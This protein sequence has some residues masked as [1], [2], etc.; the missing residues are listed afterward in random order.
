MNSQLL[1]CTVVWSLMFGSLLRA[2]QEIGFVERFA[3]ASDRAA[4]LTELVTG[5][6]DYYFYHALHFQN[7]GK[8]AELKTL[9]EEWTAR[10]KESTL[11]EEIQRRQALITYDTDPKATLAYLTKTLHL[12][13]EHTQDVPNAKP[14]FP[15]KL[16]PALIAREVFLQQAMG[17][18][19]EFSEMRLPALEALVRD[20]AVLTPNQRRY[21]I[22]ALER[23]DLPGLTELVLQDLQTKESTGFGQFPIHENLL[24]PQLESLSKAMP[25]LMLSQKFVH[26]WLRKLQP[27]E[28]VN[29]AT[30][31]A[32]REQWLT[33]AYAF[34]K[35]LAPTFNSLKAHV[36]FHRL[37]HDWKLGKPNIDLLQAYLALPWSTPHLSTFKADEKM[38][39]SDYLKVGGDF[40][41]IT[42]FPNVGSDDEL[43]RSYLLHFLAGAKPLPNFDQGELKSIFAEANLTAGTGDAEKLASL[44]PPTEIELLRDRVD[45]DFAPTNPLEFSPEQE[46]ALDLLIKNV[47][48]LSVQIFELN[49][50]NYYRGGATSLDPGI[51]LDGLI[52]NLTQQADYAEPPMRRMPRHFAFP[53]LGKK[54]GVWVIDFMGNGKSSRALIRKG[55][56]KVI[57]RISAAGT[58]ITVLDEALKPIPQATALVGGQE[59]KIKAKDTPPVEGDVRRPATPNAEPQGAAHGLVT[60]PSTE[61][62]ILLPFSSKPGPQPVIVTD[63]AGFAQVE[64]VNLVDEAYELKAGFHVPMESL[65][66]GHKA[67]VAIRPTLSIH[68]NPVD[69][70]LLETV[71]LTVTAKNHDGIETSVHDDTLKLK[72]DAE[73]TYEFTVPERLASLHFKLEGKIPSLTTGAKLDLQAQ[74]SVPVAENVADLRLHRRNWLTQ[75][76]GSYFIERLGLAGEPLAGEECR[77]EFMRHEFTTDL[78]GSFMTDASGRVELG[79]LDGVQSIEVTSGTDVS[80]FTIPLPRASSSNGNVIQVVV[81]QPIVLPWLS[82]SDKLEATAVSLLEKNRGFFVRDVLS[83]KTAKVKSGYLVV[84]H[85]SPGEYSLRYGNPFQTF[86]IQVSAGE[87]VADHLLGDSR[88]MDAAEFGALQ[89]IGTKL[90]ANQLEISLGG[91]GPE[92]RLHLLASRF[93]PE[94]DSFQALGELMGPPP[95]S[96]STSA[97][98]ALPTSF[99]PS[100]ILDSEYRYLLDRRNVKKFPG[101]ML[102]RPGL[103]LN[104]WAMAQTA[105]ND[106]GLGQ[107][108][109]PGSGMGFVGLLP[110]SMRSRK[111]PSQHAPLCFDHSFLALPGVAMFN[112]KPDKDGKILVKRAALRDG[113]FIRLLAMDNQSSVQRDLSLPAAKTEVRD[114]RFTQGLDPKAHFAMHNEV[115]ILAKDVPVVIPDASSTQFEVMEDLG[116]AFNLYRTLN[117]EA[118]LNEFDWLPQWPSLKPERQRELYSKYAC[119]E[120][121][122]FLQRKDP[123]FFKAVVL[124]YLKNKRD[125]TFFDHYLLGNDLKSYLTSW[126]YR[127]LNTLERIL[128]AQRHSEEAAATAREIRERW[129]HTTPDVA[130]LGRMFD[131]ALGGSA[132]TGGSAAEFGVVRST[133]TESAA[134]QGNAIGLKLR[135][136]HLPLLNFEQASIEEAIS[137]LRSKSVELDFIDPNKVGVNFILNTKG[138]TI[139]PITME[140]R[141]VPLVVALDQVCAL[142]GLSYRVDDYAVVISSIDGSGNALETRVFK[143]DPNF[144]DPNDPFAPRENPLKP[145]PPPTAKDALNALGANFDAPGSEATFI[146]ESHRLIVKNTQQQLDFIEKIIHDLGKSISPNSK[147]PARGKLRAYSS[148]ATSDPFAAPAMSEAEQIKRQQGIEPAR[149]LEADADRMM[150]DGDYEGAINGFRAALRLY[151]NAP[152]SAEDRARTVTKFSNSSLKQADKLGKNGRFD[153]GKKLLAEALD[154][155]DDNASAKTLLKRLDDPDYYNPAMTDKDYKPAGET[156]A[157]FLKEGRG[158]FDLGQFKEAETSFNK[159]LAIDPHNPDARRLL[160]K[161]EHEIDNYLVSA[162]DHTRAHMLRMVDEIWETGVPQ[163]GK[164]SASDKQERR[165]QLQRFYRKQEPTQEW[166]EN[167]Y[168]QLRSKD[169]N[170]ELISVNAFWKDYAAWDG[171][172][173]FLSTN[174]LEA[175]GNF[176]EILCALAVLDLPFPSDAAIAKS[177]LKDNTLTLTPARDT[178]LFRRQLKPADMA[179]DGK[180]LVRQSFFRADDRWNENG[181]EKELKRVTKEFLTGVVYGCQIMITNPTANQQI[182]EVLLQIP[183]G[184]LPVLGGKATANVPVQIAAGSAAVQ[185]YYFYF[186]QPGTYQH[187]PVHVCHAEKVLVSAPSTSFKV[188]RELS[189]IDQTSWLY[190]SQMG[191]PEQVLEFIAKRNCHALDLAQIAW[192]CQDA[193]FFAKLIPLLEKRRLYN[194]T[195]WSYGIKHNVLNVMWEYL[196]GQSDFLKGCGP[197]LQCELL[198]ID[199]VALKQYEHLEY[200]PLIN[201][202]AHRMGSRAVILNDAFGKHYAALLNVLAHQPALTAEDR[203]AVTYYLLL[204]DRLDE[205]LDMFASVDGKAVQEQLQLDYLR[206][207]LA[208]QQADAKT[209]R[210]LATKHAAEPVDHWRVKFQEVLAQVE[211]LEGGKTDAMKADSREQQ[212]NQLAASEP[213]LEFKME[214]TDVALKYQKLTTL[215]VNYYAMDLEFLFSAAPFVSSDPARF[216]LIQPSKTETL[217]LAADQTTHRFALPKEYHRS[218]VLVEITG[219]GK[220]QAKAHFANELEVILSQTQGRLQVL[221]E[222]EHRPLSKVYVKVYAEVK[223]TPQFHKD[224]YTDLRGK[225][226]YVSISTPTAG[227]TRYSLLIMSEQHGATVREVAP[228]QE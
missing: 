31:T 58:A 43:V 170:A 134:E 198:T 101:N 119:H 190:M 151:P 142:A 210:E 157:R 70:S 73:A 51:N 39:A 29:L 48:H 104:P 217:Q 60:S 8:H 1:R 164:R 69:I 16:E 205:A 49:T 110:P 4:V 147:S 188:V 12:Q 123:E 107:V 19:D 130:E 92:T 61:F 17:S 74:T 99:L 85:L 118:G 56:L 165:Q 154:F 186:P 82:T 191:T 215:T 34:V 182:T 10:T 44:I 143:P 204:Q 2:E 86:F 50:L 96:F 13:F 175:S 196:R 150:A 120:L 168:Y 220:K 192:R 226:D 140:L 21:V 183:L 35:P 80:T 206:A 139:A 224:G 187:F 213:H 102:P 181:Q 166:A 223:G 115:S 20:K 66:S 38:Q 98:E 3:L 149:K 28:E 93:V 18:K 15:T 228:P 177:S 62:E 148:Q 199:P 195:L 24:L 47:P 97:W 200:S 46:V 212:Q 132:L 11:R 116:K 207:V 90:D 193:A 129:E 83:G 160:E 78:S 57:S 194:S 117:A 111:T 133:V 23:P 179:A 173:G 54:R 202:R 79:A 41:A 121:S 214:G 227:I 171:K 89:I 156:V 76:D 176:T 94:F 174:L 221:H 219:G 225:F 203:L 22:S 5:T 209:A 9:L 222:G 122:F 36:L 6:E 125:K 67:T 169:T 55:K 152:M 184:A 40:Q 163:S 32:A 75:I 59:F 26:A 158:Y 14:D 100:R 167:N 30:N 172:G 131:A 105:T 77:I 64:T 63:G 25:E 87:N 112:L 136:T 37:D 33:T 159:I 137:F 103:L 180:L 185:E 81:G 108:V 189:E 114:L 144:L 65:V 109:G 211:E 141:D 162:R 84:S 88:R 72:S 178:L 95:N 52:P 155:D 197:A 127:Q 153:E 218:N 106:S 53:E 7:T 71:K 145:S 216:S 68:K 91:A 128:L 146:K 138:K 27:N 42:G 201:A 135:N 113:Q 208:W 45:I 124:P 161:T 126:N